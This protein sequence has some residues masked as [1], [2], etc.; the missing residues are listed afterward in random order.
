MRKFA[1]FVEG[2]TELI[3]VREFLLKKF[4]F[5]VNIECRTLF[6]DGQFNSAEYDFLNSS[7]QLL[8]Q[9]IN[10]GNDNAVISKMLKREDCLWSQG[11][12]AIVCLRDM[13][14]KDYRDISMIVDSSVIDRFINGAKDSLSKAKRPKDID[15]IFAIMEV[16][17]W[18]LGHC[19]LFQ[20]LDSRLT[21]KFILEQLKIDLEKIDPESS[22]F[23][24]AKVVDDI[25][26]T[27]GK[28]Y[29][30]HKR[31]IEK[32]SSVFTIADFETLYSMPKCKTFNEFVDSLDRRIA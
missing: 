9:I 28:R 17:A 23:H 8:F 1:I 16:E 21:P 11:F 15:F 12:E 25:Y 2:Q 18:F 13:Y 5:S 6:S 3:F 26:Q 31:D 4:A 7:S 27:I 20:S 19:T 10:V 29:D 14:S 22:I 30:K 24:P 32:I